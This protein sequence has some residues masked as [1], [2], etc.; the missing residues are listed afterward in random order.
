M[1]WLGHYEDGNGSH[2]GQQYTKW[3]AGIRR[4]KN[5][6]YELLVQQ[7]RGSNQGYLEEHGREERQFRA[8]ALD[9]LLRIGISEIRDDEAFQPSARIA[10]AIRSSVHGAQEAES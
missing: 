6:Q 9:E 5:G 4:A 1:E 10:Q 3:F 8:D 7:T 2:P